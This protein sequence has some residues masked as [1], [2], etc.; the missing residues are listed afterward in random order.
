MTSSR[1]PEI[2]QAV[3]PEQLHAVMQQAREDTLV[4]IANIRAGN[5]G[6]KPADETKCDYC[7]FANA[8]R[9]E[10]AAME[11]AKRAGN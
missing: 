3:E 6:P 10:V 1:Y 8:C 11:Q 9:Y 7:E 2:K 5:I 4:A